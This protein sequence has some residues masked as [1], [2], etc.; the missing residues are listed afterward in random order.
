MTADTRPFMTPLQSLITDAGFFPMTE[1][2]A[3]DSL[4]HP[5]DMLAVICVEN[6]SVT[7]CAYDI[8][9][10]KLYAQTDTLIK[11]RLYGKSGDFVDYDTFSAAC[12]ELF[13]A[14]SAS[15]ELLIC[16]MTASKTVQSMP[17]KRL[18]RDI[19]LTLRTNVTQEVPDD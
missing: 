11:L 9:D 4:T 17:L 3:V 2:S 8:S 12:D 10:M 5:Q 1:F 14:L 19:E 15:R 18:E 7:A 6:T 13:Y 16:K